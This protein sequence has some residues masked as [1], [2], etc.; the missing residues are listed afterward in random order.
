MEE[1][2]FLGDDTK[3]DE[4]DDLATVFVDQILRAAYWGDLGFF[5][6]MRES[7]EYEAL[8]AI[9]VGVEDKVDLFH[10]VFRSVFNS[11]LLQWG[12]TALIVAAQRGHLELVSHLLNC[13]VGSSIDHVAKVK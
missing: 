12:N 2:N 10:C 11:L 3:T 4:S 9:I 13:Q 1:K 7:A 5:Q 8:N 6:A